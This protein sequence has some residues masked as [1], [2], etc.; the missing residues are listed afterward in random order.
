MT[1]L[2]LYVN[3]V[4]HPSKP[5]TMDCSSPFGATR[6]YETMFSNTGIDHED[7]ANMI[8]L[9]MFTKGFYVLRFDLTTERLT[10]NI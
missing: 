9:D 8:T 2:T 1:N 5:R 6:A 7:R 4:Q 10:R 3:G